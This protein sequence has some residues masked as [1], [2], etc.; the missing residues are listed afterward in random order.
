ME[1]LH[2]QINFSRG[3]APPRTEE[4]PMNRK[5]EFRRKSSKTR[6]RKKSKSKNCMT[7]SG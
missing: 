3:D 1:S 7:G 4:Q 2:A 6:A 5:Q